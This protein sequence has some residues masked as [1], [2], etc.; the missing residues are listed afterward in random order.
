MTDKEFTAEVMAL[1]DT[2]SSTFH[3]K[4]ILVIMNA[5]GV[6][7]ASAVASMDRRDRGQ[8]LIDHDALVRRILADFERDHE[9]VI[10]NDDEGDGPDEAA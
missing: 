8:I 5:L 3:G 6:A 1:V 10:A 2:L 7:T 4:T 9:K